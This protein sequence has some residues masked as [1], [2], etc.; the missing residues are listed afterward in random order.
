MPTGWHFHNYW[1]SNWRQ[2][3]KW[4][5]YYFR[6]IYFTKST[7][8]FPWNLF[9]DFCKSHFFLIVDVRLGS[10]Y[11]FGYWVVKWNLPIVDIPNSG[12]A[13][14]SGQNVYSQM[15]SSL[16]NSLPKLP[17]NNGQIFL[18]PVG[19]RYSDF[20]CRLW[21]LDGKTPPLC[22]KS[23]ETRPKL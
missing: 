17:L 3:S 9:F 14:N 12:H 13:L 2:L 8:A 15:W 7:M 6:Y 11:A 10:K 5:I 16:L 19:V 23:P 4:Y 21:L 1:K 20:H 22:Q 18:R